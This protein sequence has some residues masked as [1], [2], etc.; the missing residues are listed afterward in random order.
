VQ[1]AADVHLTAE[2]IHTRTAEWGGGV[3]H[4]MPCSARSTLVR[5]KIGRPRRL[6]KALYADRG[7]DH[8]KYRRLVRAKGIRP[9]AARRGTPTA[10]LGRPPVGRRAER[11]L[12]PL[13]PATANPLADPR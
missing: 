2:G 13:V 7:L 5:G 10:R 4:L 8:D 11:R 9:Y 6:P 3:T 12:A 1:A